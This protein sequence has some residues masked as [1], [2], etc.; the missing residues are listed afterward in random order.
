MIPFDAIYMFLKVRYIFIAMTS[1]TN[2]RF[3]YG[4]LDIFSDREHRIVV[5]LCK[6]NR[7]T[8]DVQML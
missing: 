4:R 3:W 6:N 8:P 2:M 1:F 5:R 7:S